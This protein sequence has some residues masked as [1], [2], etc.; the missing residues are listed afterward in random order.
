MNSLLK[1]SHEVLFKSYT[2][3]FCTMKHICLAPNR[4]LISINTW[5]VSSSNILIF[6]ETYENI[7]LVALEPD[8]F[9]VN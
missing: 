1:R 4:F 3:V 2:C 8:Y 9:I 5:K 6:K 7:Y